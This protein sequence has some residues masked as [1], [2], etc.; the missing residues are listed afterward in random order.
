MFLIALSDSMGK[1]VS[2]PL[3]TWQNPSSLLVPPRDI[4]YIWERPQST[5]PQG[6][7]CTKREG[8]LPPREWAPYS[9]TT[10]YVGKLGASV[11]SATI[12]SQLICAAQGE[13]P[14]GFPGTGN[15][16]HEVL[17]PFSS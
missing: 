15:F 7:H 12:T 6:L 10:Q 3:I 14:Q 2:S 8:L 11:R 5:L 17:V 1:M 9:G 16:C 4:C 13:K